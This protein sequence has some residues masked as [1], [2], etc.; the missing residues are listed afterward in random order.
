VRKNGNGSISRTWCFRY[1]WREEPVRIVIGHFVAGQR[2]TMTLADAREAAQALRRNLDDGVDPRRA[3]PRRRATITPTT[4]SAATADPSSRYS[5]EFLA[6]EF[7]DRYVR[8]GRKQPAY[9]ERILQKDVLSDAAWKGRDARSIK[10]IE[11]I[12]LLDGVVARGSRVMANRVAAILGQMFKFGI[13]RQI[14]DDSPVKLLMLPGGKEKSRERTLTDGEL[15]AFLSH[16]EKCC[17]REVLEHVITVLLLTGQRRGE[18]ALARW[19][20]IDFK[21]ATWTIPDENSKN[22]RGHVVPLSPWA[23]QEFEVLRSLSGKST[24]VLPNESGDG[25]IDP[26][27]LTRS[28]A[29][30][31]GKFKKAGIDAFT[32]HDLRRTCRTGL[33]RLKIEP[34][35]AERVLNHVQEKIPGTYDLH[36]YLAE[37]R[38]SLEKWATHLAGLRR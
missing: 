11:V 10:P 35:I 2:D 28:V 9:V 16:P 6:S 5:I 14:V 34:H 22:G 31:L 4:L 25:P 19:S 13:H 24:Y 27:L 30:C 18:L 20:E 8:P 3:G 29:R 17:R 26:K 23:L 36:D 15:S 21:A 37:K 12:Q 33:A 7:L 38:V 1:K 32:L